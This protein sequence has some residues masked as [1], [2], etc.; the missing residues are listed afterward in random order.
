[1]RVNFCMRGCAGYRVCEGQVCAEL[2]SVLQRAISAHRITGEL[3]QGCTSIT[4]SFFIIIILA[5]RATLRRD[6]IKFVRERFA[7]VY[8][9]PAL[10]G[11]RII[12]WHTCWDLSRNRRDWISGQ[13]SGAHLPC[14]LPRYAAVWPSYMQPSD[15]N[16][17]RQLS[18]VSA[19]EESFIYRCGNVSFLSC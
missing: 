17:V 8:P 3:R 1:M 4:V 13:R 2:F 6:F 18:N 11:R 9:C 10:N 15:A 12:L 19:G 16:R 7:K 5:R 14:L